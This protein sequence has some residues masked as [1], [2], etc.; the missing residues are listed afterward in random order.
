MIFIVE[1]IN[2]IEIMKKNNKKL[3]IEGKNIKVIDITG[4]LNSY[5]SLDEFMRRTAFLEK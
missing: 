1:L 3:I 5:V 2:V 4:K